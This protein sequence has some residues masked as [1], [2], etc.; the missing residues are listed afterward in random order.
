MAY[1]LPDFYLPYPPRLNP[2][3]ETAR[4][5]T[6]A[7]AARMGFFDDPDIWGPADLEAHDYGLM[8]AYAHPDCP[9]EELDLITDWYAWV[10]FFDDHFLHAFKRTKDL[11]GAQA[12]L[13]RIDLFM[14]DDPPEPTNPVELG[15]KDLWARTVPAMTDGWRRRFVSVTRDLTQES[16]WELF[17]IES[18]LVSNP[19]E[20]IEE[21]R[22][23]G[24]APWSACLVEH[25]AAAELPARVAHTR[26]IRVLTETFADAVHLRN[27]LFSYQREVV[28]EGELSN[29]VLVCENFFGCGTQ[30]G[31]EITNDMITSRLHQ[32]EHTALTE[33]PALLAEH[34]LAPHEQERVMR[35]VKGLQDWQAGGHAWHLASSRYT[36]AQRERGPLNVSP[37]H[38]KSGLRNFT[39]RPFSETTVRLPQFPMPFTVRDNPHLDRARAHNERWCVEMGF[40]TALPGLPSTALWTE[41]QVKGFDM[42]L[43]ASGLAPEV[44]ARA[45]EL[46]A[47]WLAWGTYADDYYPKVYGGGHDL[48]GAK[49]SNRRLRDLMPIDLIPITLPLT[50]VERGLA[51][52]WARTATPLPEAER[53]A[54]RDEVT[55][56]IHSWE[57]EVVNLIQNRVPDPVDYIEMRRLTF[58]TGLTIRLNRLTSPQ[59]LPDELFRTR[60]FLAMT[61]AAAD[62]SCLVN[63][64]FSG[65]KEIQFEGDLHNS[66]LVM[67]NFF[68]CDVDEAVA[69][70]AKLLAARMAEFEHVVGNDLPAM[71]DTRGA[72]DELRGAVARY[73]TGLQDWMAGILRWHGRCTRYT[74]S[75]LRRGSA[76]RWTQGPTGLGTAVSRIHSL[77]PMGAP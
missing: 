9:A 22:K 55:I 3:L 62:Y 27:D 47:D 14:A 30:R 52:L 13:D 68:D 77:L 19:I 33:L 20:Y 58:G 38:V 75:E 50:A 31:V 74:E 11:K 53:R 64:L 73:V 10:F 29:S 44:D 43:C 34:A 49:L 40:T 15:L 24:G 56:M 18:G 65:Q 21:R 42:A 5:H 61:N 72:D 60:E 63:D 70:V 66:V 76:V 12:Y 17:H 36:K 26:P 8:C 57:W 2:H 46:A 37:A 71:L 54:L 35:Y 4:A 7:W 23:V 28:A 41:G 45:L 32:F 69:V 25:A 67:R 16:M 48:T 39:Y 51:D 59:P 6:R 1:E